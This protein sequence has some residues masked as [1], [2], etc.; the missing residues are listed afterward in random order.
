M[1]RISSKKSNKLLNLKRHFLRGNKAV[2]LIITLWMAVVLSVIAYS[3]ANELQMEI[4]LTKMRKDSTNAMAMARAGV[5]RAIMDLKNDLLLE[6]SDNKLSK[7]FDAEG[8]V[9]KRPEEG[10]IFQT[11]GRDKDGKYGFF[12]VEVIDEESKINLNNASHQ[13]LKAAIKLFGYE[14]EDASKIAFAII[15]WRDPD[16]NPAN[17]Q[18]ESEAKY[19]A[20]LKAEDAGISSTDDLPPV[21]LKNDT[22]TTVDELL[23]VYGI[24]PELF[25]GFDPEASKKKKQSQA[26][27]TGKT[28]LRQ[29]KSKR[30]KS[31]EE[32]EKVI[33]LR[34]LFTVSS[35][36]SVNFNTASAEVIAAI[37]GG[38]TGN[39]DEAEEFAK[40]I[41]DYRR[42]SKET[43]IDNDRAF[44]N[45][46]ELNQV[47]EVSGAIFTQIRAL[48]NIDV[49]SDNFLI[50]SVGEC[51]YAKKSLWVLVRRTWEVFNAD[52]SNDEKKVEIKTFRNIKK[53]DSSKQTLIFAPTTRI[54][55]WMER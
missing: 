20:E 13:V 55:L 46:A 28:N 1:R 31:S 18:G 33:G 48:Q 23:D 53:D 41:I 45:I 40:R 9:W 3:L 12:N 35:N 21:K 16:D 14:D 7:R 37:I 52:E 22:F 11:L 47:G 24:T 25:Y 50:H 26:R 27:P 54:R 36:G 42:G 38:V 43:D 49:K 10:K 39:V 44:R 17:G 8:D 15:D 6:F 2:I 30:S 19:Y 51:G 5:A 4:K 32:K 34:D 29:I